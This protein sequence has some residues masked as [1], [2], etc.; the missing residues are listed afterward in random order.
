MNHITKR[1]RTALATA[2]LLALSMPAWAGADGSH[3]ANFSKVDRNGDGSI[4]MQEFDSAM[5]TTFARLDSNRDGSVTLAE[6]DT[7]RQS[8]MSRM[9]SSGGVS[10]GAQS[11]G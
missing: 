1:N 11:G 10:S 9:A 3:D 4:S 6:I 8:A 7:Q 2:L 5:R